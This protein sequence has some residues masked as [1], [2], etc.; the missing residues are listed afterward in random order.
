MVTITPGYLLNLVS[1]FGFA[2]LLC[3]FYFAGM[4]AIYERNWMFAG[5]RF[6]FL[7]ETGLVLSGVIAAGWGFMAG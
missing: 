3:L 5:F 6:E 2:M 1:S 4:L 7:V